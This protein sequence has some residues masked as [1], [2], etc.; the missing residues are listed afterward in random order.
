MI[1]QT[2][3]VLFGSLRVNIILVAEVENFILAW[4]DLEYLVELGKDR[5]SM[6]SN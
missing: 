4:P 2:T 5:P 3:I 6:A 1:K